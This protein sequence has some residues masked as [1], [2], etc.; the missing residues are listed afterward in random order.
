MSESLAGPRARL[1]RAA[2]VVAAALITAL[3]AAAAARVNRARGPVSD[4]DTTDLFR[5]DL[6]P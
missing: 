3:W 2:A 5:R 1:I 6:R 4:S